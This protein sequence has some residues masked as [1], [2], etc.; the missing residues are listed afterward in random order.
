[1]AGKETFPFPAIG[2]YV[3]MRP[4]PAGWTTRD[5]APLHVVLRLWFVL[6]CSNFGF[7]F[8]LIQIIL[9]ISVYIYLFIYYTYII[10]NVFLANLVK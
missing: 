3:R 1:M 9:Y 4:G 2:A 8:M 10:H 5:G 6:Y 7:S